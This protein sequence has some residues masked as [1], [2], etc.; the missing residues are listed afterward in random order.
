MPVDV[1]VAIVEGVIAVDVAVVLAIGVMSVD[2]VFRF[3]FLSI[4]HG[5]LESE[6]FLP[7]GLT[8]LR[9]Q[10]SSPQ[11]GGTRQQPLPPHTAQQLAQHILPPT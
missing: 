1:V 2:V 3:C 10:F 5:G 4:V 7:N 8:P 6:H 9:Q 11:P